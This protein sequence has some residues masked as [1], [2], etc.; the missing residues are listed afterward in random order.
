[1]ITFMG[2]F[3]AVIGSRIFIRLIAIGAVVASWL[4]I[5]YATHFRE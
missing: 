2:G 4:L 1:M 3:L 5:D